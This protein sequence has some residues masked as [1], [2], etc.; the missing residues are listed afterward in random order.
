MSYHL[1]S[2]TEKTFEITVKVSRIGILTKY[3]PKMFKHFCKTDLARSTR[4]MG[5]SSAAAQHLVGTH[6]GIV[7]VENKLKERS[8]SYF[9]HQGAYNY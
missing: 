2:T 1:L 9:T 8:S 7:L 6:G 5:F 3:I 4:W